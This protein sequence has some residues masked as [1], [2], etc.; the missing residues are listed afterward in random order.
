[1]LNRIVIAVGILLLGI[2]SQEVYAM[3]EAIA[4]AGATETTKP[5]FVTPRIEGYGATM[6][7]PQ[8][9]VPKGRHASV[10]KVME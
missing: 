2:G 6:P 1:M 3:S 4:G 8:S 7:L 10:R 5:A 9:A